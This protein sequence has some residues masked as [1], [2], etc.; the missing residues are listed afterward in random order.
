M[1]KQFKAVKINEC[2]EGDVCWMVLKQF[3]KP[4]YGEIKKIFHS[5][6]A[7]EILTNVDGFRTALASCCFWTEEEAKLFI[8][9]RK[10]C[11]N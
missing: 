2:S 3:R 6:Q 11:K 7:I 10:S 4:L 9:N 1:S 8:R 5:E